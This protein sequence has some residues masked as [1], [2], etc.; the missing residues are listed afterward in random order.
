MKKSKQHLVV[1]AIQLN[2]G[3]DIAANM[4]KACAAV[5]QAASM[6]ASLVVLP[7]HFGF[8]GSDK[9]RL[10]IAHSVKQGPLID[11]LRVLAKKNHINILA[12]SIPE[13]GPDNAH[14]YNTSVLIG[15]D[16]A[17][18]ASYR[19]VHLFFAEFADG[20]HFDEAEYVTAGHK[21]VTREVDDWV[22]G[23]S[24]CYD[25]RFP[26][27]YQK[28]VKQ[29][30]E[31]LTIP[32]AF[33]SHTGKDHWEVLVRARAIETQSFVIAA[34]QIGRHSSHWHTWGKSMI[35]DPWGTVLATAPEREAVILAQLEHADLQRIRQE[36]MLEKNAEA[37][38]KR[39]TLV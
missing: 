37:G 6:G 10:Q 3:K 21:A 16:G 1:A 25:L 38:H 30:A 31:I 15:K 22:L 20:S 12:G 9:E 11:P 2:A 32:A 19:K 33:T 14:I 13:Q 23:F 24:I 35:V 5:K 34:A 29:G 39:G 27:L 17:I 36:M 7:E 28:L 4:D 18:T 8:M 26:N